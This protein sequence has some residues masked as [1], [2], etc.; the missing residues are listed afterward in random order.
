MNPWGSG[1]VPVAGSMGRRGGGA[2]VSPQQ[3]PRD[4]SLHGPS[5]VVMWGDL[6]A[7]LVF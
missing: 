5:L 1:A 3:G 2:A 7:Q 6:G 4:V